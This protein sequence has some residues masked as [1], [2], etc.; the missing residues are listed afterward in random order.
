MSRAVSIRS[1]LKKYMQ[2]FGLP[3]DSCEGDAKRLRKC[4]VTGYWRNVARWAADGTYRAVRGD[5]VS[6]GKAFSVWL[7]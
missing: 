4:L 6:L 7:H 3:L 1:Q 5:T 2:R